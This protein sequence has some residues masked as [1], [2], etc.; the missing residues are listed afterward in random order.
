[1]AVR[2]QR[3]E[4]EDG[5]GEWQSEGVQLGGLGSATGVI[6]MWTGA[7]HERMDPL[8]EQLAFIPACFWTPDAV[9]P[10]CSPCPSH[11]SRARSA[12]RRSLL[13]MESRTRGH[14]R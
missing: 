3:S 5:D 8:G 1:M 6:G 13:G 7:D 14:L 4:R 9:A 10:F 11:C 2:V 12:R